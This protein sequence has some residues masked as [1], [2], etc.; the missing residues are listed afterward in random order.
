MP[1]IA[2][3]VA[4]VRAEMADAARAHGRDPGGIRLLA[5][6]KTQPPEK[7]REA[8]LAGVDCVGE[9]RVQ[10]MLDKLP[11]YGESELHFIGRLQRN[12][13]KF[14][15]GRC[16]L[17][18]SV[19]SLAL[20]ETIERIAGQREIVQ[21]ILLEVNI[22]QEPS[23]GGFAPGGA[24]DAAAKAAAMPHIRLRGLMCIPPVCDS[25]QA[26]QEIFSKMGKLF[27]DIKSEMGYTGNLDV[28]SMGMSGDFR[29]AIA[30]GSTLIRVGS[31]LF[32]TR[33]T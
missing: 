27:V 19:D 15:V 2:E 29:A 3:N 9:N 21:P 20:L 10:E 22:G 8:I 25:E 14:V 26:Q 31:G 16:A 6:T 18:H 7:I 12:K 28:L 32:G 24:A 30:H 11:A 1:S 4:A 5:A 33:I 13:V 23:K 17:I